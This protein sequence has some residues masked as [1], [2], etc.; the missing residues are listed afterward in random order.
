MEHEF[1]SVH[2]HTRV[3]FPQYDYTLLINPCFGWLR[4]A[5]FLLS[6]IWGGD[7]QNGFGGHRERVTGEWQHFC[8]LGRACSPF[9]Y[10]GPKTR[11]V[12][13]TGEAPE[14]GKL[15][16]VLQGAGHLGISR[17]WPKSFMCELCAS[18]ALGQDFRHTVSFIIPRV[19]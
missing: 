1:G 11:A 13:D 6:S 4:K 19:L 18:W 5:C 2:A 12:A 17:I 3:S 16:S 8:P 14:S 9:L 15:N 7:P 10:I